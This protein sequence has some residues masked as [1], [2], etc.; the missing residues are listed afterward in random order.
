MLGEKVY[1]KASEN[2]TTGYEWVV[3]DFQTTET[4]RIV[5]NSYVE[6]SANQL[7]AAGVRTV[8]VECVG[9]GMQPIR[10]ANVRH[11][12]WDG[13]AS[14]VDNM[15]TRGNAVHTISLMCLE[16]DI[17]ILDPRNKENEEL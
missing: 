4:A 1:I 2:K 9:K 5:E 8:V 11:W 12:E 6:P 14:V 3:E 16:E 15:D 7:G 17:D 13:F 10:M